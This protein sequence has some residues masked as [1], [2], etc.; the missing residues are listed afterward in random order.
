MSALSPREREIVL[1]IASGI[2]AKA[3]SAELK[4][5]VKTVEMHLYKAQRKIGARNRR[6]LLAQVK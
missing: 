5:T 3:V 6:E 1:L 4:I 2:R